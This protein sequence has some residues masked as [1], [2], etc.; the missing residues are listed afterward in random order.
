LRSAPRAFVR[1]QGHRCDGGIFDEICAEV[2]A[3]VIAELSRSLKR[4]AKKALALS[5]V[6]DAL[7]GAVA[8]VQRVDS[9]VRLNVHF[10]IIQIDGV[11]LPEDAAT[12]DGPLSF[13]P[14]P[15]PSRAETA[16]VAA[17]IADRVEAILKKHGR[18]VDPDDSDSDPTKLQLKHP[19]LAACYSAA[20]LGVK[21]S[22]ARAGQPAL[23]LVQGDGAQ[24]ISDAPV[25][26]EPVAEVRGINLYGK[27]WIDGR[28]RKQLER[29][30]RYITRPPVA[31]E[32]LSLRPDGKLL[33]EFKKAWKDGTRA[34]VLSLVGASL[35]G[36]RASAL[37]HAALLRRAQ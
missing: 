23:R 10:H 34:L 9:A 21:V 13:Y 3:A 32:R 29:L 15:T 16:R 4:R 35:R 36:N 5:S 22:G 19:A 2:L 1:R 24:A 26:D 28:D 6:K 7:T 20:A 8:A 18:S 27:Q 17:R 31:Q 14:L 33:L 30:F 11:Y 25:A 37:S 12:D